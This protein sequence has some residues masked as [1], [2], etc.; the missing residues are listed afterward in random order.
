MHKLQ[1]CIASKPQHITRCLNELIFGQGT[2][3]S[4]QNLVSQLRPPL[5]ESPSH[6]LTVYV[7]VLKHWTQS[8]L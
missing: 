3:N 7:C 2:Q 8:S 1:C 4:A 6:S 5:S